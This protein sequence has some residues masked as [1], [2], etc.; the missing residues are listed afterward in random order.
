MNKLLSSM[1]LTLSI[2]F[3]ACDAPQETKTE[4]TTME[5]KV[6]PNQKKVDEYVE[7]TL[8]ADMSKLSENQRKMIPILIEASKIMDDLFWKEAYGDKD[9]LLTSI[10]DPASRRFAEINYGPWDRLGDNAPFID[11]AGE[12]PLGATYYPLDM[13]MEEWDAFEDES[14]GSLYTMIRRNDE[15]GLVSIPF[16]VFFKDEVKRASD[17]LLKAAELAEDEGFKNYLTLRSQALLNDDYLESDL[18]WMDMKEN[19]IDFVVGPIENYEDKLF[20]YKAAHEAYV[21]IKDLSW[22]ER[23]AKYVSFLPELQ[24]NLPVD[25]KYKQEKPGTESDLNAYDVVYYAGDCNAGSKTIAINLPNDE[26]VQLAKGTRRLQL[27]NAMQAKFDKILVPI[28]EL[29]IDES[30]RKHITFEAFFGNT[31]FHEVAHGL[32]IKSTI[33]GSSTVRKALKEHGSALEEGKADILGVYMITQ[34]HAK[35]EVEGELMDYYTTFLAGIFRSVRFGAASAH[36]KAN[37]IRFNYF[38]EMEAF[39]YNA[40]NG[41]Y[42]VNFENFQKAIDGLSNIILVLQGNGDYEGVD[43]LFNEKG[44]VGTQLEND[45]QRVSDAGIPRD[46][47]F[48][49]GREVLGL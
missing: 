28:S 25:E 10:E 31:M 19:A 45:L 22:S 6:S 3:N 27:K 26:R 33:D 44:V 14:K 42:K 30:Q 35:G 8:T 5:E 34:L 7:F 37:M 21:L 40:E 47:T 24:E 43:A 1:L 2:L 20:N 16:N 12:K 9:A 23:L 11:G 32:G 17:L 36:G 49:Q 39:T 48:K 18:A 15:G 38:Q 46:V 4:E 41:T 13:T 29:L